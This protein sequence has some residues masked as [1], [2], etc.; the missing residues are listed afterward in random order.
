[1]DVSPPPPPPPQDDDLIITQFRPV[2][3]QWELTDENI[4]RIDPQT[5]H[6]ILHNYCKYITTIPLEVYQ[7]LI[8]TKGCDVNAQDKNKENTPLHYAL[9]AFNP[10]YG[11][12][13]TALRYLL[14]Q[15]NVVANIKNQRGYTLLHVACGNIN[16]LP[17]EIFKFLIETL[18]CDVNEQDCVKDTP[19]RHAFY[20]FDPNDGGDIN[21]LTY[22]LNHKNVNGN[23]CGEYNDNLLHLACDRMNLF[24]LDIF[25]LLVETIGCDV[26]VQN[27]YN[28]TPVH[29]ALDSFNSNDRGSIP[30][31]SYLINQ[32]GVDANIIRGESG[33][34]LLHTVCENIN[35]FPLDLFKLLIEI[36][37]C[38]VNAQT[39][40]NETPIHR[41]LDSF[42]PN[43]GGDI[44]ILAYLI[45]QD[46]VN[47]N[48]KGKKGYTLLHLACIRNIS[49]TWDSVE[50]NAEC[51]TV[52]SQIVEA[53]AERCIQQVLD[54]TTP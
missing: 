21:A 11:G 12:D 24:P 9:L 20:Y 23:L 46:C 41:A 6:T 45:N 7:Y 40:C 30:I 47:L 5:G 52:L 15:C 37:G 49:N 51:D 25:K 1:M 3:G 53:I 22:L 4:K 39:Y 19:I 17:I 44:A 50:Q 2:R 36:K 28:Q 10:N 8:K 27:K 14:T 29:R 18:G 48:I 34:T 33:Y 16:R 31:L 35:Y 43:H 54:E 42:N 38:D 32:K 26:N 13:I